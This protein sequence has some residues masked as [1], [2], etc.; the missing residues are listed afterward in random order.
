MTRRKQQYCVYKNKLSDDL[1]L[2]HVIPLSLGGHNSFCIQADR[3]TNNALGSHVDAPVASDFLI[4]LDRQKHDMRG[5]SKFPPVPVAKHSTFE[6]Q[7]VQVAFNPGGPSLFDVRKR[8]KL[9]P[10]QFFGKTI[11]AGGIRISLD[12]FLRFTAKTALS[13]GYFTYGSQFIDQVDHE[14]ARVVMSASSLDSINSDVR[15]FDRFSQIEDGDHL[16]MRLLLTQHTHSGVLLIPGYDCFGVAVGILGN[17]IGFINIPA[18]G[19]TLPNHGDFDLGHVVFNQGGALVRRSFRAATAI[20][21]EDLDNGNDR[22]MA[23]IARHAPNN[24]T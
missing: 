1:S 17:F 10:E 20:L 12:A 21:A 9:L 6:N 11:T 15:V 13:A 16:I 3:I 24:W 2:E 5:H 22:L 8:K 4:M 14:Q 19:H 18:P 7:K 23:A